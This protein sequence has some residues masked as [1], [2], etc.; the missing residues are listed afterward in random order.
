MLRLRRREASAVAERHKG[1][2]VWGVGLVVLALVIGVALA[3]PLALAHLSDLVFDG[4]QRLEPREEAGAPVVVVDIDERSITKI[5]QWPWPRTTVAALVDRLGQFGAA[6]IAF[7]MVFP[8]PD[9]TSPSRV[10][11]ELRDKGARIELPAGDEQLDN[12]AALAASFSRNRVVA[13]IAISN[14]NTNALP[15]PKAGFAFGGESPKDYLPAFRGGVSNLPELNAAATGI[16]FFSFPLSGDGV[17]RSLPLLA[18]ADDRL[19]PALSIEALRVAQDAG[20][21]IVRSTGASGEANTGRPAMTALKDGD[22]A[23]PTGPDGTFRI[24]YSGLPRMK[25]F[26]AADILDPAKAPAFGQEISGH[27]VL[28][29]TSAVG[30]RDLV[31]TPFHEATPGVRVHAEII[32][33][34]VGQSF[35]TRPDWLR[36]AEI[37]LAAFL[38]LLLLLVEWRFGAVVN[39]IAALVL[40]VLAAGSSWVAFSHW[41]LL[42]DP[43]LP[44]GAVVLVFAAT[45]PALLLL[46]NRERR[47]IHSAFAHYLSPALVGRLAENPGELRLGGEIRDLTVL[48]SDIR[49]FTTLSEN[50]DPDELTG[51]LNDFLTPATDVLL[52]ADATIDKYIGD[53]IMAFWNAPLDIPDHPRKACLAALAM[54]RAVDDLN[55]ERGLGLR[56]GIGLNSGECC[57]GNLGSAQRFSY[58]AIGDSVNLASRIEGLTK[59]YGVDILV[60]E[61]IREE[62]PDLA[63]IEADLVRVVGRE[64]PIRI[65]TLVGDA[66]LAGN[67]GFRAFRE[68]HERFL[69]IYR[70]GDMDSALAALADASAIAPDQLAGLYAVYR[71]RLT[72]LAK[73]PPEPGWDGVFVAERK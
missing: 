35:L 49:G 19:Y 38:G 67:E 16:G 24:Y 57:V 11:A 8:E 54:R 12:D 20:S 58:S 4:Y 27:I 25:T 26:S 44:M 1:L 36:G 37:A 68:A 62:A 69:D 60:A 48:F 21:F 22:F 7:D 55:R 71:D 70:R 17:V 2:I 51:L 13:G 34:I 14:E 59:Q 10:I 9:R 42:M 28:V 18:R 72:V 45:T 43:I 46:A 47:F 5:G 15:Q 53:A 56:I 31:A 30:L 50:L 41:R 65:F 29:G 73:T 63:F 3:R 61:R 23:M 40:I 32:D 39:S 52:K 66:H 64:E 33:Q 6:S